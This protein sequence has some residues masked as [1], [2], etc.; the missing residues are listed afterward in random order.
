MS[1]LARIGLLILLHLLVN[2]LE[3]DLQSY[4]EAGLLFI[5]RIL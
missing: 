5:G 2:Y 3:R 1:V 4:R